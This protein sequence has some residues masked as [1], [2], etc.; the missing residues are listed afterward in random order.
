MSNLAD[1]L[2]K[3]ISNEAS[4]QLSQYQADKTISGEIFSIVDVTKGEYKVRYQDGVWSAFSQGKT[5]YKIGDNVL[6]KI[7]LGDFSKTKYIEGYTYNTDI[8]ASN[9][10]NQIE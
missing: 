5:K 4:N 7:P 6:V 2:Y 10:S 9:E 1:G 3:V 8:T